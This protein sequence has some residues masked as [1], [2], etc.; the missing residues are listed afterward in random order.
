MN[1]L[2]ITLEKAI[3]DADII[4]I[5]DYGKGTC[6]EKICVRTIEIAKV[7]QVIVDP[8][9]T[10]WNKYKGATVITPNMNEVNILTGLAVVNEDAMVEKNY[11]DLYKA[12]QV[13]YMLLTRSEKGMSLV[14]R[15]YKMSYSGEFP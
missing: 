8:K 12:L 15:W 10:N 9:G 2:L 4:V 6:T 14:W 3:N 7:K 5:S 1:R 11:G 13:K